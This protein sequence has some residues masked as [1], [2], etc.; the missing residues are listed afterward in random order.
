MIRI[1]ILSILAA[2]SAIASVEDAFGKWIVTD[3]LTPG[4]HALT[5]EEAK[6]RYGKG[7]VVYRDWFAFSGERIQRPQYFE[8]T[9]KSEDEFFDHFR[10]P[11]SAFGASAATITMIEVK[12]SDGFDLEAPGGLLLVT[13]SGTIYTLWDGLYFVLKKS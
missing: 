7:M 2:S 13:K 3:Y 6:A 5:V 12:R 4:V 8:T 1:I 11:T 10:L 9:F